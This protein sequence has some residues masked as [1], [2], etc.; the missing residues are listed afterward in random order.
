[1][2]R[3][4]TREVSLENLQIKFLSQLANEQ[5]ACN[6]QDVEKSNCDRFSNTFRV[7]CKAQKEG[8]AGLAS[9]TTQLSDQIFSHDARLAPRF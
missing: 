3:F 9:R 5:T 1:M 2:I 7:G 6:K 8:F 4:K